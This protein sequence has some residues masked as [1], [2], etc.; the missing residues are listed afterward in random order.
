MTK[1][2]DHRPAADPGRTVW[3]LAL[4]A[5]AFLVAYGVLGVRMGVLA[6]VDPQEPRLG[7]G[8][9]QAEPVRGPIVDRNGE[10]LAAN[11]PAWSL[12]AHP[13]DVSDPKAVA[14]ELAAIFKGRSA[15]EFE[16]LLTSRRRF[17]WLQR[18]IS[19][20]EKQAVHDLGRPGLYFGAREV[21]IYPAGPAAAHIVG[22]VRA[23]DEDV[24]YARLEG[25]GGIEQQ[26]DARLA[27]PA[28]L[29]APLALSIDLRA[30]VAMRDVLDAY[31]AEMNAIGGAAILMEAETGEVRAMVSLPDFDPNVPPAPHTGPAELNPRFNR[32]AQGRY[33]LGSTFKVLTAAIALETGVANPE[34]MIATGKPYVHGRR[35]IRDMHRMPDRM[36]VTDIVVKSSNVGSAR[37][38]MMIGTD[39]MKSY[40][41]RLGFFEPSGVE[42]P[43][44]ASRPLL[45]PK[46]TDLSTLT[47]SYGHGLA[48]SPVHLAAAY[49]TIANGGRRVTPTLIEGGGVSGE[50]VFSERT[51]RRV[52]DIMRAVVSRGTARRTNIAGY[53]IG[54]KT[55]TA[56]KVKPTGGYYKHKVL[57]T[58]ASAFPTSDPKYVLVV[59]LDEPTDTSGPVPARTAGRTAVPASAAIVRRLMPILGLRP[60]ALALSGR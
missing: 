13:R 8:T 16:E 27:D 36:S 2:R 46:W 23:A 29:A 11:L 38:A 14:A 53:E 60:D 59:M 45:P 48:A 57:S 50:R 15:V 24:R 39:R 7:R 31:I 21:R 40:L 37:L 26:F 9:G 49:A 32:A 51:S 6:V 58:F 22:R 19:P 33:E 55:G 12:Y 25:Q 41:G 18:P 34:T 30:Q 42:L 1:G 43:E 35:R 10:L 28:T 56:D 20:R 5:V 47:I 44:A 54:G 17:V 3:R 52:L 4:V